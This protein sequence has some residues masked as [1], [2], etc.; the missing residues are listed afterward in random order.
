MVGLDHVNRGTTS[1]FFL[2]DSL[3]LDKVLQQVGL[4]RAQWPSD[5]L[6][7]RCIIDRDIRRAG[8]TY[9]ISQ[10]TRDETG[11]AFDHGPPSLC[12]DVD[13][14]SGQGTADAF[15]QAGAFGM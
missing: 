2:L 11:E 8:V 5:R 1:C 15:H 6:T 13:I 9:C 7:D 4:R 12:T 3:D 14:A 10:T